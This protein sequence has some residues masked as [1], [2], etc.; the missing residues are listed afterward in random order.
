MDLRLFLGFKVGSSELVVSHIYYAD[1]TIIL[2][3]ASLENIW[4]I[5]II[6]HGFELASDLQV[7]LSKS[8][9]IGV[10][11]GPV[12]LDLACEFLHCK[13]EF[14]S[15][16]CLVL[17]VGENPYQESTREPLVNLISRRLIS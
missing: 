10:N 6:L 8:S 9:L 16:K 7:K 5:N 14:I 1:Y 11:Y 17:P 2:V 3:D 12:F 13:W 4:S 15:F